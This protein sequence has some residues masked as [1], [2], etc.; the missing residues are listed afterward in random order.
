M[1]KSVTGDS[2][3][4][5]TLVKWDRVVRVIIAKSRFSSSIRKAISRLPTQV[6]L[7]VD[8]F[9][10]KEVDL[11][12]T[13]TPMKQLAEPL[14]VLCHDMEH[15]MTYAYRSGDMYKKHPKSQVAY[16]PL[17][18][19]ESF[20]NSL[21]GNRCFKDQLITHM[22]K[23]QA[24]L[25]HPECQAINEIEINRYLVDK[26]LCWSFKRRQFIKDAILVNFI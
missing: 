13:E 5:E 17:C 23:L 3:D 8:V 19:I 7:N 24:I 6:G 18:S 16:Y 25:K 1:Y 9:D 12:S 14:A 4:D 10:C 15:T 22:S 26:G 11:V 20:L 21:L 2:I